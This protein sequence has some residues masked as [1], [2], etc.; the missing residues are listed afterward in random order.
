MILGSAL[1]PPPPARRQCARVGAR[2]A[3]RGTA[4]IREIRA[5]LR[6]IMVR[7]WSCSNAP[8]STRKM[9]AWQDWLRMRSKMS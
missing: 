3:A 1:D 8:S 2:G 5:D 7:T 6:L 9:M 4:P